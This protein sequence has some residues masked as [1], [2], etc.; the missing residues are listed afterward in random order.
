MFSNSLWPLVT[1]SLFFIYVRLR[2][3]TFSTDLTGEMGSETSV[4]PD[5]WPKLSGIMSEIS[6]SRLQP[7]KLLA[8]SS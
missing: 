4:G 6:R 2:P 5:I 8:N 3:Q 1:L 7:S